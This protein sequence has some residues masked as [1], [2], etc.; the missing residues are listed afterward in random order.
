[1]EK[2]TC[3]WVLEWHASSKI[4]ETS[5][6]K[7]RSKETPSWKNRH[8]GEK[9]RRLCQIQSHFWFYVTMKIWLQRF[10]FASKHSWLGSTENIDNSSAIGKKTNWKNS[11]IIFSAQWDMN[12]RWRVMK[13]SQKLFPMKLLETIALVVRKNSKKIFGA[14]SIIFGTVRLPR[15]HIMR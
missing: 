9:F 3:P 5:F 6:S 12:F 1:M 8:T 7:K 14:K 10:Q 11:K 15:G 4:C 2:E 13:L